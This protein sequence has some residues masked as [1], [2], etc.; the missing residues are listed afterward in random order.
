VLVTGIGRVCGTSASKRASRDQG[1][2]LQLLGVL[3][4]L[5]G[6]RCSA[7]RAR[8][9]DDHDIAARSRWLAQ[10]SRRGRQ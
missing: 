5:A 10:N 6:D 7:S 1:A 3:Q 2:D 4:Y 9:Q 8:S